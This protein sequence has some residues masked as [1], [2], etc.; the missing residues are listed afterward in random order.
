MDASKILLYFGYLMSGLLSL[1]GIIVI[2]GFL[3]PPHIPQKFRIMFGIV[4]LLYGIYRFIT[5]RV[6]QQQ[7]DEERFS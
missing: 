7:K 5:L 2:S 6:K 4:L 1:S 3:L